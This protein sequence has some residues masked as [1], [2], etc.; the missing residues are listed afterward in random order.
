[1]LGEPAAPLDGQHLQEVQAIDGGHDVG[2]REQAE[3]AELAEE[4]RLILVLQRVVEIVVPEV[5]LHFQPDQHECQADDGGEQGEGL[6]ALPGNP[7]G[8]RQRPESL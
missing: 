6:R 5:E 3:L 4:F 1:V 7:V 8:F 2:E